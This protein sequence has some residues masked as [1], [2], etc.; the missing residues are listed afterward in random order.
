[1]NVTIL[2]CGVFGQAIATV[3]LDN[4]IN[5]TIWNK[6]ENEINNIKI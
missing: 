4:N 6:F 5:I 2:G 3:L 1:M